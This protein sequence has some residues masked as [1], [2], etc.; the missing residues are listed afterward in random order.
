[1]TGALRYLSKRH[2][3]EAA[4]YRAR[5]K[6]PASAVRPGHGDVPGAR[7]TAGTC[8]EILRSPVTIV[9]MA[10]R[11]APPGRLAAHI[12]LSAAT[13]SGPIPGAPGCTG[14]A[15]TDAPGRAFCPVGVRG[16]G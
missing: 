2:R 8:G 10:I 3:H 4:S 14:T 6:C 9:A 15:P 12:A 13:R 7:R 5:S 1:M 11:Q 16:S